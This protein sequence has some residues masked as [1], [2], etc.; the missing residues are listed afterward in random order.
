[1]PVLLLQLFAMLLLPSLLK[2]GI[3]AHQAGRAIFSY[4]M[5]MLGIILMTV[6]GLPALYSVLAG[7]GFSSLAYT[8][9]LLVFATGGLV[10]LWMDGIIRMIDVHSKAIPETMFFFTW[11][12]TGLLSLLYGILTLVI[13]ITLQPLILPSWWIIPVIT[14]GYGIILSWFTMDIAPSSMTGF[15]TMPMARV[16]KK[17]GKPEVKKKRK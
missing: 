16:A 13:N 5:Q 2:P 14:I 3:S 11:K 8:G 12:A 9:L 4:L 7:Q 1:M 17:V 10:F 6:S 15:M